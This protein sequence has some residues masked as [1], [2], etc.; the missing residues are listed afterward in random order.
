MTWKNGALGISWLLILVSFF[1]GNAVSSA[2]FH[3]PTDP[4]ISSTAVAA[5]T[6]NLMDFGAVGDGV[7]DDGPHYRPL[8]MPWQIPAVGPSSYR[9]D[10]TPLSH[11]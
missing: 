3:D 11:R 5:V 1:A 10:S 9:L 7:S 6:L 8:S 2:K 4:R